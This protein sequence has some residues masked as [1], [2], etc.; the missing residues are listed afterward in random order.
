MSLE[1]PKLE[2]KKRQKARTEAWRLL[3]SPEGELEKHQTAVLDDIDRDLL[4]PE[5]FVKRFLEDYSELYEGISK[6]QIEFDSPFNIPE[7][8]AH[9]NKEYFDADY[10]GIGAKLFF[11]DEEDITKEDY[12]LLSASAYFKELLYTKAAKQAYYTNSGL[13]V[14]S[15]YGKTDLGKPESII[16]DNAQ[17]LLDVIRVATQD[18][19]GIDEQF[20]VIQRLFTDRSVYTHKNSKGKV[21]NS[22]SQL[23][24]NIELCARAPF[25]FW[26]ST[27]AF[28]PV[29]WA[30]KKIVTPKGE[31]LFS[32]EFV[33]LM[34]LSNFDKDFGLDGIERHGGCPALY[35]EVSDADLVNRLAKTFYKVYKTLYEANVLDTTKE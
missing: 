22:N 3:M 5:K 10:L 9:K 19:Q 18:T 8:E 14:D 29:S 1:N 16:A 13:E 17:T 28:F 27:Q 30:G 25:N 21:C 11:K 7:L 6:Y 2:N 23:Q 34:S 31:K 4:N 32:D 24:T 35:P 15:A 12:M 33:Y 20:D 26:A